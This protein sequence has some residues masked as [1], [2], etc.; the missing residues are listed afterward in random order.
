MIMKG[1]VN[2]K[3]RLSYTWRNAVTDE[4]FRVLAILVGSL[5][6]ILVGALVG[7]LAGVGMYIADGSRSPP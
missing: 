4:D 3:S 1:S 2:W 6:T 7:A 5:V